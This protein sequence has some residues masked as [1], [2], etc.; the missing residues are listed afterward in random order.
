QRSPGGTR[1]M[2]HLLTVT[3]VEGGA[4]L[5]AEQPSGLDPQPREEADGE[6]R[7]G[8]DDGKHR[9]PLVVACILWVRMLTLMVRTCNPPECESPGRSSNPRKSQPDFHFGGGE[10]PLW[11]ISGPRLE[12][13][14][15]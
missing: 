11:K 13:D 3:A 14:G 2:A 1:G 10:L 5:L 8:G 7:Y 12:G 6:S 9:S 15:G 4:V